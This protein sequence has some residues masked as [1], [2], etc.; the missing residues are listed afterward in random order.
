MRFEGFGGSGDMYTRV[1][2]PA[3]AFDR[4]NRR[5]G[6]TNVDINNSPRTTLWRD[7]I[8]RDPNCPGGNPHD[9]CWNHGTPAAGLISCNNSQANPQRG[10]RDHG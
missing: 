7:C 6:T 5:P 10:N 1:D 2:L 3:E 9:S 4:V 8:S